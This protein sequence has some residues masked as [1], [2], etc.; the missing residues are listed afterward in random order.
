M[1]L[2]WMNPS[3]VVGPG[4]QPHGMVTGLKRL[5]A[6]TEEYFQQVQASNTLVNQLDHSLNQHI[7]L[8]ALSSGHLQWRRGLDTV[9]REVGKA[10]QLTQSQNI[11]VVEPG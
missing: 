8:H 4:V 11:L 7:G 5:D 3:G 2:L 6:S 1:T 10:G 9:K